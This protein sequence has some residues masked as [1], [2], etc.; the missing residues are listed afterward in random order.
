M[1]VIG[2]PRRGRNTEKLVDIIS[3]VLKEKDIMVEKHY[4]DMM[5]LSPCTNC[6]YCIEGGQ[7]YINDEISNILNAINH[8]DGIILASPSYNY[9][10]SAQMKT[11]LDRTFALNDYTGLVWRSRVATGK[12][13]IVV[14]NC[15]GSTKASMGYTT[16]AMKK[17]LEDLEFEVLQVIEYFDTKRI[18]VG[19]NISKINE[20]EDQIRNIGVIG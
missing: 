3:E 12:Q 8:Y 5:Q 9:N 11:L 16:E 15:K 13:A 19:D 18:P 10:V 14:G 20:V 4:L 6:E 1:A 7:C 2:S 17:V